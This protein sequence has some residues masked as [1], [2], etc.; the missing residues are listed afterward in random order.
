MIDYNETQVDPRALLTREELPYPDRIQFACRVEDPDGEPSPCEVIAT[1][2]QAYTLA[3]FAKNKKCI[4][5]FVPGAFTPTCSTEQ[6]PSFEKTYDEFIELGFDEVYCVTVNDAFVANAW[7]QSL[8]IKKVKM[9]PDGNTEFTSA[10]N[11]DVQKDNLGFAS[12]AWRFAI[13]TDEDMKI[14][15]KWVEPGMSDNCKTD[16]YGVS[17]PENILYELRSEVEQAAAS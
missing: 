9:I 3:D 6:L 16:P 11:A 4:F 13:A 1:R 5:F 14:T 10:L 17:D 2:W 15:H 8:G 7:A 12:R